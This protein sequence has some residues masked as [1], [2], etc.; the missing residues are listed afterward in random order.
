M[1]FTP[2][3]EMI[4]WRDVAR[5]FAT[6][7]IRPVAAELDAQPDPEAAWSWAIVEEADA[8]G[9]RQAPLPPEFGGSSTDYVT[10]T[11]ILEEIAA[12]DLGSAV[13][14]AQHWKFG[15]MLHE[16]GTADQH[17]RYLARNAANPRGLFAASFTEPNAASDNLL[18]YRAPGAGMQTFA[19]KV[20]GGHVI[21]GFKHY[22][23]NANRSDTI[24]CF[25]R[26]DREGPITESVT[27]FVVPADSPGLRIGK[28]HDKSG[29]RIANNSEIFYEGVFVPDGATLGE[30]GLALQSV[31]RL[32]RASNSYAAACALGIARE[33]FDRTLDWCRHRVQGGKPIVEH[34]AVGSYLADMYVNVDLTRNYI[35][36]AA[37]QARSPETFDPIL[38]ITPKLVASE[39]VFESARK[40]MELWGGAGV[41]RENGIEKLLR[42]ASIWLHSDGTNIIMR[43][44]LANVLRAAGRNSAAW[45]RV[46]ENAPMVGII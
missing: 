27:A 33:C 41:M 15:Q 34:Q 11:V 46:Q 22:I 45:D 21:N 36:R 5:D 17:A 32:L 39:R 38:A 13:V 19:Q 44:R 31:G 26:T 3:P 28:V 24:L 42:D 29:E 14:L 6:E 25:A 4:H 7:V 9:L 12:A 2:T 37:W 40:A 30:P 8:R 10:N 18:P 23:S 16:L 20:D 43:E 1:D 35:W